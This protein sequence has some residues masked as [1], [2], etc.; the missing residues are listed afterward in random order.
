MV[1][2]VESWTAEASS[3][4]SSAAGEHQHT[5]EPRAATVDGVI[6]GVSTPGSL[7]FGH[8]TPVSTSVAPV[9]QTLVA[10]G[11]PLHL[12]GDAHSVRLRLKVEQLTQQLEAAKRRN[13]A[14]QQ[15]LERG[16]ARELKLKQQKDDDARRHAAHVAQL[17]QS[18]A[19]KDRLATEER[20]SVTEERGMI[21]Q[22]RFASYSFCILLAS[23]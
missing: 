19:E 12:S 23:V 13:Q 10:A 1:G 17:E 18:H 5:T 14:M 6:G 9:A 4:S 11:N 22:A 16:T 21:H 15:H 3:A 20:E 8:L 7:A 2:G